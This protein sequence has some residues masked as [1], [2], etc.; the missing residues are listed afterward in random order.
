MFYSI[1]V[2]KFSTLDYN[3]FLENIDLCSDN[4]FLNFIVSFTLK[5]IT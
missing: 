1:F 4:S 5:N 3:L 2:I